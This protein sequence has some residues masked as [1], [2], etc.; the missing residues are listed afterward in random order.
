[1]ITPRVFVL[2]LWG[3]PRR[4]ALALCII[5]RGAPFGRALIE[6]TTWVFVFSD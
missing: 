5:T 3:A 2:S 6:V 4:R 1:M